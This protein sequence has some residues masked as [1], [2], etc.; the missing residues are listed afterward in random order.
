MCCP[1]HFFF[2]RV[3]YAN[4]FS[5]SSPYFQGPEFPRGVLEY[6]RVTPFFLTVFFF[7]FTLF[8]WPPKESLL[9]SS[10]SQRINFVIIYFQIE[11]YT[12]NE[13]SVVPEDRVPF[14]NFFVYYLP[15]LFCIFLFFKTIIFL[16]RTLLEINSTRAACFCEG[17]LWID[18]R[19]LRRTESCSLCVEFFI[20]P[21]YRSLPFFCN[22]TVSL[23]STI[24]PQRGVRIFHLYV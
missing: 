14:S 12:R 3:G 10:L 2:L 6:I 8:C 5:L 17:T 16:N 13:L 15:R 22:C 1:Y 9:R 4:F 19:D 24:F 21:G 7:S 11:H 18:L 20:C 23:F